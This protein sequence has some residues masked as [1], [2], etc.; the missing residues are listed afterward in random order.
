MF[1]A[2]CSKYKISYK[3]CAVVSMYNMHMYVQHM[4]IVSFFGGLISMEYITVCVCLLIATKNEAADLRRLRQPSKNDLLF[5]WH[6]YEKK[7][8]KIRTTWEETR[9]M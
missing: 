4:Q 9:V 6:T 8:K 1:T 7:L 3:M 5:C 2:L